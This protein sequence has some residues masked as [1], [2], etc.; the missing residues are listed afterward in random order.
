M[1]LQEFLMLSP[2]HGYRRRY[3]PTA[4]ERDGEAGSEQMDVDGC[5]AYEDVPV[6]EGTTLPDDDYLWQDYDQDEPPEALD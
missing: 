1:M 4:S 5:L 3:R 6:G 2:T